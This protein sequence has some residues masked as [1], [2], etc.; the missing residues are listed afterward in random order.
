MSKEAGLVHPLCPARLDGDPILCDLR[1]CFNRYQEA[2]LSYPQQTLRPTSRKHTRAPANRCR[3]STLAFC[4][5]PA[6]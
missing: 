1:D 4:C 2:L 6:S 5:P 3:V